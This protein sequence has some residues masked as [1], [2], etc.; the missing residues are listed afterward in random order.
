MSGERILVVEDSVTISALIQKTLREQGY[1]VVAAVDNGPEAI[2]SARE[3]KPDIVLM[4][5]VLKGA[6]TGIDAAEAIRNSQ[7]IP[8]IYL[9]SQT[10]EP[11]VSRAIRTD[12][13]G[14]LIKPLDEKVLKTTIQVALYKNSIETQLRE[15]ERTITVLL[16]AIPDAL[17]LLDR[18]L[19][20]VAVNDAMADKLGAPRESLV[21]KTLEELTTQGI[22]IISQ[23]RINTVYVTENPVMSEEKCGDRWYETMMYPVTDAEGTIVRIAIQSHDITDWKQLA[24]ELKMEGL[25]QI[26]QNMEQFQ[27]LND[28]IRNPLQA[29]RGL[30]ALADGKY[31]SRINEQV[32]VID[33]LVT[34]LDKGWVESEKVRTFLLRHYRHG[35]F[36]TPHR[37]PTRLS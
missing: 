18:R 37:Q 3:L 32:G 5:I 27:V 34:R 35:N 16:N 12:P 36:I 6:M 30:A 33:D 19:D 11:T 29:I 22:H 14:Y 31:S 20:I 23:D 21:G 1:E 26:E 17:A 24:A 13:F 4:D 2:A 9:T 10:D 28:R 15:R 25:S 7:R 8:V